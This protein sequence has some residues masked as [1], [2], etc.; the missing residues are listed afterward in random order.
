MTGMSR[1]RLTRLI[2]RYVATGRVRPAVYRRRRFPER[3]TWADI[4]LLAS[5]DKAHKTLSGPATLNIGATVST[6]PYLL[7][8]L[9]TVRL[10]RY[11]ESKL[12]TISV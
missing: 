6:D 1:S 2:A 5:V 7:S 9:M 4:E 10:P 11:I 3:Y 12:S 8:T